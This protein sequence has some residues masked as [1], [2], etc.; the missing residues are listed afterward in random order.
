MALMVLVKNNYFSF[1]CVVVLGRLFAKVG[2]RIVLDGPGSENKT[3]I[4]C[5]VDQF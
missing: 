2:P 5:T 3:E 1:N 4:T